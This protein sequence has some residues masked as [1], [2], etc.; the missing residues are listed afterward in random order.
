V[1]LASSRSCSA[2]ASRQTL[3]Q[4]PERGA[5][6][7]GGSSEGGANGRQRA[8]ARRD[9]EPPLS[10]RRF[11]LPFVVRARRE[12]GQRGLVGAIVLSDAVSAAAARLHRRRVPSHQR[13]TPQMLRDSM[14][15]PLPHTSLESGLVVEQTEQSHCCPSL[16]HILL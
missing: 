15:A 12:I 11:L 5:F 10:R 4:D 2:T 13:S 3:S 8:I 9:S 14:Q 1:P 6:S 16:E 7:C